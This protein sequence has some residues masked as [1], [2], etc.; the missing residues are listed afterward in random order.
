M[1]NPELTPQ[2]VGDLR[3]LELASILDRAKRYHQGVFQFR[4][5][6]PAC[7]LG[8][9]AIAHPERWIFDNDVPRLRAYP[10]RSAIYAASDDFAITLD[11]AVS[12]FSGDGCGEAGRN[13]KRAAA[14]IR[15]FV[16]E[17]NP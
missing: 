14:F 16:A 10:Y 6:S 4:C 11:Q 5:G 7:A 17:R 9:W 12:I 3:L 1:K 15:A 8:H 2:Q 13:S